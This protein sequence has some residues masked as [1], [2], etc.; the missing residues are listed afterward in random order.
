MDDQGRHADLINAEA[1]LEE[2]KKNPEGEI[3]NRRK[4]YEALVD[5]FIKY[6]W[7]LERPMP[8]PQETMKDFM[9]RYQTDY[10][11]NAKVSSLASGVMQIIEKHIEEEQ[12]RERAAIDVSAEITVQAKLRSTDDRNRVA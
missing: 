11:F 8:N 12:R 7:N 3:I 1:E 10:E 6:Q 5:G 2:L 4:L 9:H